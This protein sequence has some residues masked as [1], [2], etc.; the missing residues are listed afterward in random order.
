MLLQVEY[1]DRDGYL[2][3][4]TDNLSAGGAFVRT[5]REFELGERVPLKLSFAGLLEPVELLGEVVWV[6]EATSDQPRG[7]GFKIPTDRAEDLERLAQV[8]RAAEKGKPRRQNFRILLVE[9]NPHLMEL[10]EYVMRKLAKSDQLNIE[11]AVSNDG[12]DAFQKLGQDSYDLMVTD[13]FMPVLDGFELIK[14]VRADPKLSALPIVAISAGG[15]DAQ[16]QARKVGAS[17]FLRKP[18]RFVDV[19]ETIKALLKL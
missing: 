11:V 4:A 8:L 1:P 9:D 2:T 6:R 16:E 3:D 12:H 10:Y 13:L 7:V 19:V 17:I 15:T 14:K 5:E 18:V